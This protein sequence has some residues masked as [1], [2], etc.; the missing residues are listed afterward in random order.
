MNNTQ[1]SRYIDWRDTV[2]AG[3]AQTDCQ[4][5]V[6]LGTWV[7][8]WNSYVMSGGDRPPVKPPKP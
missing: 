1:W 7:N 6:D 8:Q 2:Q 4:G 3:L 5:C